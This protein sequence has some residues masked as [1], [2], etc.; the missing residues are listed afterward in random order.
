[1]LDKLVGT[2]AGISVEVKQDPT[3]GTLAIINVE[4]KEAER[5]AIEDKIGEAMKAYTMHHR[6][7]W[8]HR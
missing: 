8:R 2:S 7:D 4:S 6:I 3:Y 1:V 5:E